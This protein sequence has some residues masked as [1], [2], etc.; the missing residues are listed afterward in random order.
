MKSPFALEQ[1]ARIEEAELEYASGKTTQNPHSDLKRQKVEVEARQAG[2]KAKK[3]ATPNNPLGVAIMLRQYIR[4]VRIKPE[5]QG[6]KAPLYFY[7]PDDGIW[8]EDNEF[9]QDLIAVIFPSATEKHAN[10]TLYKIARKSPLRTVEREYTVIGQQLYNYKD[11]GFRP[12]THEV[13]VTRKVKTRYNPDA[14]EPTIN[15]WKPTQ[16]L[17]ELFDGDKELANL[18]IQIIKASVTGQSL[19][20]IFWLYGE[21]GTGKGTF[22]QLLINLVGMENVAS[23]RITDT[24]KNNFRTSILLGKSLVIGDDVQKDILIKD[25]SDIFSL[26]TGDIMTIEQKGKQPYSIKFNM[27]IV[28]SSNGLPRMTGDKSAID[29]RFRV[30]PFTKV[31]KDKPNKAIKNDYIDRKAVLEYLVKLAI[32][33]PLVDID[34]A[35]S[36]EILEE[37]HKDINPVYDFV[38]QFFTDELVSEFIPNSFVYHVWKEF[39]NYYEVNHH[40]TEVGLHRDIK[41]LLPD[42]YQTGQRIIPAGRNHHIGFY[43]KEDL[44]PFARSGLYSNGRESPERNRKPKNERGYF[45]NRPK[46]RKKG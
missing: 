17:L 46:K 31:F 44:P 8:L 30:L 13:I 7:H 34:P 33:T 5:A 38:G 21:G 39:V 36:A 43:P 14:V 24:S 25:T 3:A 6:Q 41:T 15:G 27:T 12:L 26:A 19:K 10:D 29:R 45:N 18:A 20:K 37:H 9:L 32:E 42:G 1:L 11:N 22:Q 23:L 35:K 28:Q 40:K 2:E 4:F 16:W